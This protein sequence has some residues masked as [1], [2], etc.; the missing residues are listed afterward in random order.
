M[1]TGGKKPG[2]WRAMV[3]GAGLVFQRQRVLWWLFLVNFV[4]G[5]IAVLPV[6][7]TLGRLLDHS[8]ASRPLADHFDLSTWFEMPSCAGR[9]GHPFR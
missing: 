5:V 2:A 7:L 3:S 8:L 1:Q 6:R 4:L 9:L